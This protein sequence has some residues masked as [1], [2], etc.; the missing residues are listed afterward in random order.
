MKKIISL[1]LAIALLASFGVSAATVYSQGDVNKD[2]QA[3]GS[4]DLAT[5]RKV[6]LNS[7]TETDM[8]DVNE[9][10]DTDILDLVFLKKIVAGYYDGEALTEGRNTF[11][12]GS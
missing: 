9:D 4:E 7:E 8:A 1:V 5:L 12:F 3:V 11:N 2:G 6:L 10:G